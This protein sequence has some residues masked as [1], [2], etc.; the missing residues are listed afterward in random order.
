MCEIVDVESDEDVVVVESDAEITRVAPSVLCVGVVHAGPERL[1]DLL[2]KRVSSILDARV[3]TEKSVAQLRRGCAARGIAF[4]WRP[5]LSSQ[6]PGAA[7]GDR[8]AAVLR[9]A[10]AAREEKGW[11]CVLFAGEDRHCAARQHLEVELS[12]RDVHLYHASEKD[13]LPLTPA[14]AAEAIPQKVTRRRKRGA[15]TSTSTPETVFEA[16]EEAAM[17]FVAQRKQHKT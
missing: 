17:L 8:A 10:A 15:T 4:D 2:E 14:K 6:G 7:A 16:L 1:L 9:L 13:Q 5:A 11:P 12:A 3:Q